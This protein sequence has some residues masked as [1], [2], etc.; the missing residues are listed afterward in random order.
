MTTIERPAPNQ[1][2]LELQARARDRALLERVERL[3]R[4]AARLGAR[5][6]GA[7]VTLVPAAMAGAA[8]EAPAQ[9]TR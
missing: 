8:P 4:S 1:A 7:M 9:P 2:V 5:I 6:D 3:E